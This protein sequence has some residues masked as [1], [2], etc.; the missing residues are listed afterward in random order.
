MAKH[1]TMTIAGSK[2]LF[3]AVWRWGRG[4][5]IAARA[6][7]ADPRPH[8][9]ELLVLGKL[10]NV[11]RASVVAMMA[12]ADFIKN[13]DRQRNRQRD[14]SREPGHDRR[15]RFASTHRKTGM[16]VGFK[17]AEPGIDGEADRF[18]LACYSD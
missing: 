6:P 5:G 1:S 3:G 13:I 15:L 11:A 12:G 9:S 2:M 14:A 18:R 8:Q 16:A 7:E 10:R 17:P 4:G